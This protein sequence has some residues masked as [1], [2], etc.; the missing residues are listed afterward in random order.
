MVAKEPLHR[1]SWSDDVVVYYLH[2][3]GDRDLP[4][5]EDQILKLLDLKVGSY[6][7]RKEN[8]RFLEGRGGLPNI[9]LLTKY[10]Y[11]AFKDEPKSH[12]QTHVIKILDW[13]SEKK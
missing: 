9:A 6:V 7:R 4:R 3:Y 10:V 12:H 11:E 5:N 8:I 2:R 13:H 1:W